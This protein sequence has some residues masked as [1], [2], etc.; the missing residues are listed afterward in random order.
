MWPA[1]A[2]ATRF[3]RIGPRDVRTSVIRPPSISKPVT[4]RVL[5]DVHPEAVRLP[6][7]RPGDAV[8]SR[9]AARG[10]YDAPRI[11]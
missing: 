10:W 4:S 7:V 5:D 2:S 9:D 3:A 1:A 11:G 8:M 6:G